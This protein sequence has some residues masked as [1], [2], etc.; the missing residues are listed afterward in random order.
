MWREGVKFLCSNDASGSP[1]PASLLVLSGAPGASRV[2]RGR[3]RGA[4]HR[5]G[6]CRTEGGFEARGWERNFVRR[7]QIPLGLF[8]GTRLEML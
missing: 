4:G 1:L 7:A 5:I 3:A 6:R 8:W 2:D